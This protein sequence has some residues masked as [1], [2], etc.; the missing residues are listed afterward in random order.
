VTIPKTISEDDR[1]LST[2]DVAKKL[3]VHRST[4]HMWIKSG[5]LGTTK[6]GACKTYHAI[7]PKELKRFLSVYQM[8]PTGE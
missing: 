7:H 4:V 3:K 1:L 6:H 2:S 5:M 8:D